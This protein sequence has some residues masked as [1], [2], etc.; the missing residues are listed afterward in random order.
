MKQKRSKAMD[1]KFHWIRD[2]CRLGE[3]NITWAAG[4]NNIADFLTKIQ[5]LQKHLALRKFF[6]KYSKA[7]PVNQ[8]HNSTQPDEEDE[9]FSD[10]ED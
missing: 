7:D 10:L 5:P 3:F 9:I 4:E 2:R 8:E 1:V 6:V